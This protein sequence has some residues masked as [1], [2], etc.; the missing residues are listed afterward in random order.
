[1]LNGWVLIQI[2]GFLKF[3]NNKRRKKMNLIVLVDK[4]QNL[5]NARS[6]TDFPSAQELL[7]ERTNNATVVFDEKSSDLAPFF[8]HTK[9]IFFDKSKESKL[10]EIFSPLENDYTC[11][12]K[13]LFDKING[14]NENN[15]FLFGDRFS[16]LLL[17]Y[18]KKVYLVRLN[19]SNGTTAF[20]DLLN[21]ADFKLLLGGEP[22]LYDKEQS[23]LSIFENLAVQK[24]IPA[25]KKSKFSD[26]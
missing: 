24:Y 19:L 11:S 10:P 17:P 4:N 12:F 3:A 16:L 25:I 15:I 23:H 21:S 14:L 26:K 20:P 7:N 5:L 6:L 13:Q 9:K 8:L 18:A 2:L 22:L 1:M